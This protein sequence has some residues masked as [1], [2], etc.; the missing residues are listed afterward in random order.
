MKTKMDKNILFKCED[1]QHEW[2]SKDY[3]DKTLIGETESKGWSNARDGYN[4][5]Q[6]NS[7]N[8]GGEEL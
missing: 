7:R 2:N 4:C 6:C 8:I 5:P 3:P 1:C